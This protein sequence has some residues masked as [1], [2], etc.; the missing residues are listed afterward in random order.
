MTTM[1]KAIHIF[2]LTAFLFLRPFGS[3]LP[4]ASAQ[5]W[6]WGRTSQGGVTDAWPVA[7]DGAGNVYAGGIIASGGD[8]VIFGHDTLGSRVGNPVSQSFWVKYSPSGAFLWGDA[9]KAGS[10]WLNNIATDP[11]GNL[12]LFGTFYS[13]TMQIG[14]FKLITSIRWLRHSAIFPRQ[15]S[16]SGTVLW[17]VNDGEIMSSFLYVSVAFV[18]S[19]ASVATDAAGNIYITGSFNNSTMNIGPYTLTNAGA[20]ADD[21]FV[22]KYSP[23]GSVIWASSIGGPFDDY[24]F[25]ITVSSRRV[26]Y[27]LPECFSSRSM[28]VGGSVL[29]NPYTKEKAYIAKFSPAG[30]PTWGQGTGRPERLFCRAGL[31]RTD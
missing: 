27:M 28:T 15:V 10:T 23:T 20:G 16:S 17:A 14:A 4:G 31:Q 9:T 24:G 6:Q 12:I 19:T 2:L 30:V 26:M 11:S 3:S 1:M 22:A 7:T 29:T 13:D 8:S 25:G 21:V 18:M 5:G